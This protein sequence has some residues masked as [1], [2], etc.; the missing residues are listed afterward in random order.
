M[1][2]TV[3]IGAN[4]Q[5]YAAGMRQIQNSTNTFSRT[6][7]VAVAAIGTAFVASIGQGISKA[8]ELDAQL[9]R[10]QNLT[11]F[12]NSEFAKLKESVDKVSVAY[13]QNAQQLALASERVHTLG[14]EVQNIEGYLES[15]SQVS[16]AYGG[17]V[18][19]LAFSMAQ[20]GNE[21][22]VTKE[23]IIA[24]GQAGG[25]IASRDLATLLTL[26]PD[27]IGFAKVAGLE[28]KDIVVTFGG[29]TR[30]A[31]SP[32]R[33]VT[34]LNA[35]LGELVDTSKQAGAEVEK[36]F[37]RDFR[38]L[39]AEGK[40]L[41]QILEGLRDEIGEQSV[42]DLFFGRREGL[43]GVSG[44][45]NN[46]DLINDTL[47]ADQ[48]SLLTEFD[49]A[50]ANSASSFETQTQRFT[51]AIDS[52]QRGLVDVDPGSP[53]YQVLDRL[54][55]LL[56]SEGLVGTF[57][58]L[59]E[60]LIGV[61]QPFSELSLGLL[62]FATA[63]V[64]GTDLSI[65]DLAAAGFV[66]RG[67]FQRTSKLRNYDME[68]TPAM[69]AARQTAERHGR[70]GR[71]SPTKQQDY[72]DQR[73]VRATPWFQRIVTSERT[74]EA[75]IRAKEINALRAENRLQRHRLSN[76]GKRAQ[77]AGLGNWTLTDRPAHIMEAGMTRSQQMALAAPG[78]TETAM[79]GG[80]RYGAWGLGMLPFVGGSMT[81]R[82]NQAGWT[83]SGG[84]AS[85]LARGLGRFGAWGGAAL[86][87]DFVLEQALGI[88]PVQD[89]LGSLGN[90]IKEFGRV[91]GLVGADVSDDARRLEAIHAEK[92]KREREEDQKA[93]KLG[94]RPAILEAYFDLWSAG[95]I[96]AADAQRNFFPSQQTSRGW[97][98]QDKTWSTIDNTWQYASGM[99]E[100]DLANLAETSFGVAPKGTLS[101]L[102]GSGFDTLADDLIMGARQDVIEQVMQLHPNVFERT[103]RD[104]LG[105][106]YLGLMD[107]TDEEIAMDFSSPE[108]FAEIIEPL[109]QDH[110]DQ[111]RQILSDLGLESVSQTL[112]NIE[113]SS[114]ETAINTDTSNQFNTT[115]YGSIS[116]QPILTETP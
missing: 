60:A 57:Q 19:Q 93:G 85:G 15:A 81:D 114:E 54:I 64:P 7:Q 115:V 103:S 1:G 6:A 56:T 40:T 101:A 80:M 41:G 50:V 11:G 63:N 67:A 59:A 111:I 66:T 107:R 75:N 13:G 45:L 16:V 26:M 88:T 49:T 105:D 65:V 89:A 43:R 116:T 53:L 83:G 30:A 87:G 102:V 48:A 39:V 104:V 77:A 112:L 4:V 29:L 33:A 38:Q 100:Q 10:T 95:G 98:P 21:F 22:G 61:V 17:S 31:G 90:D 94:P 14:V 113:T 72:V 84:V 42:L 28:Y 78:M 106:R 2:A 108:R 74:Q 86:A 70:F 71:L 58:G 62:G 69:L 46:L 44:I 52:F 92:A 109:L 3:H 34:Q 35:V 76:L 23:E 51:A 91:L 55:D 8:S 18:D 82:Y 9:R 96:T 97:L 47:I 20:L 27:L 5:Q 37:G 24:F 79:R 12:S 25:R 110:G 32:E 99:L 73:A 68:Q 36:V